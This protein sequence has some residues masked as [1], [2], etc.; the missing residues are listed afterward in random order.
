MNWKIFA[1]IATGYLRAAGEAKKA[2]DTNTT[3]KD[4]AL[5]VIIVFAADLVDALILGRALPSIP[6]EYKAG[7]PI[8]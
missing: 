5:G 2:E 1:Q 6:A 7:Q 3:G 4:D 8:K